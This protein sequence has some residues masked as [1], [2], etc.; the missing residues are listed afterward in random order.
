M[1]K[2]PRLL[3]NFS[4]VRATFK[5]L[6]AILFLLITA[7]MYANDNSLSSLTFAQAADLAL[8][9]SIELRRARSL[10]VLREGAWMWGI[11][12]YFPRLGLNV[13]ENDRLQEIGADSFMKNYGISLDQLVWDGGRI[14]MS[15]KLERLELNL[16]SAGLD[17]MASEIAESAIAAY[18]NV[19]S[20]R[21]I[22]EIRKSAMSVLEEQRRILHEEVA[23][24]F[25]LPVDLASADINLADAKL[26][27]YS[28]QLDLFEM[29]RQFAELMGL[30][31]L[32]I[33]TEK[34]DV[35][36]SIVL[37]AAAAAGALAEE[38]NPD[39]VAA[40]FSIIKKQLELKYVS[41]SWKPNLRLV[42][43]F[44]LSGQRYPLTSY[45]WSIGIN[46]DF[47]SPWFQNRFGAQ[48][49]WEPPYDKS[50]M[51]QN[52]FNPLPDP[53]AGFGKK[54]AALALAFEQ[55]KY[56]VILERVGRTAANAVEK[57]TLVEQK[58][59]L[60]LDS[61]RLSEERCHLEEL[62]LDLGQITR[63]KLMETLIEQTQKEIAVVE[64]AVAL[65]E[66]ERELERFLDLKPGELAAFAAALK[67]SSN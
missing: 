44:G 14:S 54:Q 4:F 62:R 57:C 5:N 11:R 46:I 64:A 10:Q 6:P 55:D 60:A 30:E 19:L 34:V 9:S 63:L 22:L 45:N 37:P 8:A 24:G 3:Q 18:R 1:R 2:I 47:S 43:N 31:S 17:R 52:S 7:A 67:M 39:L 36:R 25:A 48:A 13:S 41:D 38:R 42:G 61:A 56:K 33:L 35:N 51:V 20:S 23:L 66:A 28:L 59:I 65:L 40:R 16:S 26:D 12:E 50:A 53:A 21:A 29:E 49:G 15:R 32:P 27:I 58:R